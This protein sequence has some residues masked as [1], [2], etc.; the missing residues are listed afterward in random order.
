MGK[1]PMGFNPEI[2]KRARRSALQ[3]KPCSNL[4][5]AKA[6]NRLVLRSSNLFVGRKSIDLPG[7]YVLKLVSIANE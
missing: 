4:W 1:G 7:R 2:L 3:R 6:T 5:F